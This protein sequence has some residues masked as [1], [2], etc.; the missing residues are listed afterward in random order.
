MAR[1]SDHHRMTFEQAPTCHDLTPAVTT[2][3]EL[4]MPDVS[5]LDRFMIGASLCGVVFLG[6]SAL[7]LQARYGEIIFFKKLI[8]GLS[9]CL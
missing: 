1:S 5:S 7:L 8:A 3:A 2:S 6:V 4:E 9:G